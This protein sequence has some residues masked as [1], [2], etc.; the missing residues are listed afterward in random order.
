[1]AC[2]VELLRK[3]EKFLRKA[4]QD[5]VERIEGRLGELAENPICDEKLEPPL[6]KLCK[7]RVGHNRI[8]AGAMQNH[9]GAHRPET[10]LL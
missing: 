10:E 9:C 6:D 8:Q 7:T 3:A 2:S 4:P 5:A 1:V